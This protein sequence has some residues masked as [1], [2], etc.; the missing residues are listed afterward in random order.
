MASNPED[1]F[2]AADTGPGTGMPG[3]VPVSNG[4]SS[5][6]LLQ[7]VVQGAHET[8]DRLAERAAPHVHR[9]QGGVHDAS[10]KLH[11]KADAL[12]ETGHEWTDDL[13]DTVR[14]HPIAAIATALAVGMLVARLTR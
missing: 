3:A 7:R 6:E 13:R 11:A 9:L 14:E 12:R 4:A 8:I 1:S 10:E 5:D 2:G